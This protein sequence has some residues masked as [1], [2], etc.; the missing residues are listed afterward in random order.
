M[1]GET[2]RCS[3]QGCANPVTH[4]ATLASSKKLPWC[5]QHLDSLM[6]LKDTILERMRL[7]LEKERREYGE[8][9][10]QIIKRLG[11]EPIR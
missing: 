8:Y 1:N 9:M 3:S 10:G 7:D 2:P 5:C 11:L 6:E 4:F